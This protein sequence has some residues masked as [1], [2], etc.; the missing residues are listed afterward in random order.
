MCGN[1]FQLRDVDILLGM[2]VEAILHRCPTS[3]PEKGCFTPRAHP[4]VVVVLSP[5][6]QDSTLR[7]DLATPSENLFQVQFARVPITELLCILVA[8][9]SSFR[10]L[11]VFV[12]LFENCS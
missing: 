11:S 4:V 8:G 10:V 2:R 9:V 5:N 3:L 7:I 1:C 12:H 6:N